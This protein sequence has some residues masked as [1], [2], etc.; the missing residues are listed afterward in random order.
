M[1][2]WSWLV[3][4]SRS[5]DRRGSA[6]FRIVLSRPT[7][8]RLMQS[9]PRATQ[10]R[11]EAVVSSMA[12]RFRRRGADQPPVGWWEDHRQAGQHRTVSLLQHRAVPKPSSIESELRHG[13]SP[14]ASSFL[15]KNWLPT[16]H[17][18]LKKRRA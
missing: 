4:A 9:T 8:S 17:F 6:T 10:R 7:T 15:S 16:D 18:L 14:K 3:V 1:I 13:V 2:H 12:L 11:L 5:A